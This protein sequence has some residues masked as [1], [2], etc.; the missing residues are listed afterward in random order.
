VRVTLTDKRRKLI[1]SGQPAPGGDL[2][3]PIQ[4][5]MTG[6]IN[7]S[8]Q[9][10]LLVSFTLDGKEVFRGPA[11]WSGLEVTENAASLIK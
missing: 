10:E 5:A 11:H 9:A 6:K 2:L 3:S 4:G 1:D 7:E 8:L